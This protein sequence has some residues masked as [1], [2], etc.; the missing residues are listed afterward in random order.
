MV[1]RLYGAV[2]AQRRRW[3]RRGSGRR[4]R[5]ARP[6]ISVGALSV[7]GSG[8]TPVAAHVVSALRGMGERPAVLS[9]GYGRSD[10]REGVV[11][12]Q[13]PLGRHAGLDEAGDEPLML[14]RLLP[15]VPILVAD[16]RYLAG[17]LAETC[18]DATAHVLDDGFQHLAL[19]RDLD[20]V[21]IGEEDLDSTETLPRGRLREPVDAARLADALI[22][23]TADP[24][25][26]RDVA[27]RF[28]VP[29]TF[30][31]CRRLQPLRDTEG[32]R[33]VIVSKEMPV[34]AVAG[35]A[36]P[37]AFF[38]ALRHAGYSVVDTLRFRD[39]HR[40]TA[41][42]VAAIHRLAAVT[43][44]DY[45]VTTDK[46]LERLRPHAPLPFRLLVA[47]LMVDVQPEGTF[48][49]CLAKG[50]RRRL[51]QPSDLPAEESH[52]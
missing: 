14:A 34:V 12:V 1:S 41:A 50:L 30:H 24:D 22:V 39:H 11:V 35:V 37:H 32:G 15:G 23:E 48:Q 4:R 44:V 3:Y 6:V 51:A 31:Y 21:V 45:V 36:R 9:R 29:S 26:A 25:R 42:D 40:Y 33:D 19:D 47:S 20:L 10:R 38:A 49:E 5:L 28:E 13:D 7:G 17:R 52:G 46:D 16:D 18:L 8:K 2:A 27:Q 43:Q